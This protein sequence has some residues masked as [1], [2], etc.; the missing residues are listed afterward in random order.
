MNKIIKN[1]ISS[2]VTEEI[3]YLL[4]G[5]RGFNIH[6]FKRLNTKKDMKKYAGKYLIR[7]GSGSSRTV[8]AWKAGKVIKIND[9]IGN[10]NQDEVDF[11]LNSNIRHLLATI[12]DFDKENYKWIIADGVQVIEDTASL[13][14][15][16]TLPEWIL[17][18]TCDYASLDPEEALG[19]A[20][21]RY[22]NLTRDDAYEP[23]PENQQTDYFVDIKKLTQKDLE[24]VEKLVEATKAGLADIA[25]YDHWGLTRDGR[26]VIVDYG[27]AA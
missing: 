13:K 5:H 27:I 14:K 23:T 7:L 4:E 20:V 24:L 18:L 22:N 16:F 2:I 10:Q 21:T 1:I 12:Y 15:M 6:F 19:K 11:Y 26:L 25:R 8:F 17:D 9:G 3:N